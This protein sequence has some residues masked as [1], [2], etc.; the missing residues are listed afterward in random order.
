MRL[1]D[2]ED[3]A[4]LKTVYYGGLSAKKLWKRIKEQPSIDAE[5][6]VRCVNCVFY[7]ESTSVQGFCHIHESI[8]SISDF[9]SFAVRREP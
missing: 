2:I 1:I 3:T 7:A 5:K 4:L 6:I 9:C 8:V